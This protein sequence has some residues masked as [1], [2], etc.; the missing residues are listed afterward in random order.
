M[1]V[2]TGP[3]QRKR[4]GPGQPFQPGQSG[5]P[6]GRRAGARNRVTALA[7]RLMDQDAEPV[8]LALIQ[9]ARGG[10]V[11][12]I[13]LVLERVAP[14]PR[15]RPGHFAMPAIE[16]A[17]DLGEA[18]SAIMRAASV[19]ELSPDEATAIASL[20]ETRRRTIETL[21]HEQRIAAL[22]QRKET[23]R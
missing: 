8:I 20:I 5:N 1:A 11:A 18:M 4:R 23:P 21:E 6:N 15:N 13:K 14:L 9:A 22:E 17:A 12:A 19:G 10:D 16:T 2:D 7:M 3:K